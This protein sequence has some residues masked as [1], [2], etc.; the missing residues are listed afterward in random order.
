M[1]TATDGGPAALEGPV[2]DGGAAWLA[3]ALGLPE[4]ARDAEV[5]QVTVVL[6]PGTTAEDRTADLLA[7]VDALPDCTPA[8]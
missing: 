7:A 4:L 5:E 6:G 8:G 3:D 2:G 1:T